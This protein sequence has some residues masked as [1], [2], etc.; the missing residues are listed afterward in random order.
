VLELAGVIYSTA[1]PTP[2]ADKAYA[3]YNQILTINKDDVTALN[4]LASL[5]ADDF[6]PPR[7]E[8]GL[9]DVRHAIDLVNARGASD[10]SLEDTYGWLLILGGNTEDGMSVLQKAAAAAQKPFPD[11]YYHLGEGYLRQNRPQ[12]AL[13]Q[14]NLALKT[15]SDARGANQSFDPTMRVRVQELSTRVLSALGQ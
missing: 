14:V 11:V 5:C 7:V 1:Q 2:R 15:I 3:V 8:E 10:P 6:T 13:Q 9:R 12:D 4:N